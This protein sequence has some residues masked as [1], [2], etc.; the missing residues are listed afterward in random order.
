MPGATVLRGGGRAAH[1]GRRGQGLPAGAAAHK[2][3]VG[4]GGGWVC[5]VGGWAKQ[6]QACMRL[7]ALRTLQD[8]AQQHQAHQV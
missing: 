7:A 8:A 3:E 6:M 1:G 2:A 4:L 5:L